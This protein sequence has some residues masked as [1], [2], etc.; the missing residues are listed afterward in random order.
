MAIVPELVLSS[1]ADSTDDPL[2]IQRMQLE[3][4]IVPLAV[5][6][7]PALVAA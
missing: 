6:T 7:P 2:F 5:V 3:S 4:D 1:C